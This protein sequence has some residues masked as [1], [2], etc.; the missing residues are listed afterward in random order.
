MGGFN[1][2]GFAGRGFHGG[3]VH[4]GPGGFRGGYGVGRRFVY[5]YPGYWPYYGGGW[6]Y[7]Y[8]SYPYY[9]YPYYAYPSYSYPSY[10][11]SYPY[12]AYPNYSSSNDYGYAARESDR[13]S[14]PQANGAPLYQIKLTYQND[15]WLAQNYWYRDGT[16]TF[17][18][19]SGEPK[20]TPQDSIDRALTYQL[21]NG[22]GVHFEFPK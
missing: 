7:P 17:V 12:T 15:I 2:G 21:N 8:Y 22:C 6:G 10:T 9:S 3:F 20:K 5:G 1:G 11:Y 19:L 4:G 16:L 13:T 18:T 14:C